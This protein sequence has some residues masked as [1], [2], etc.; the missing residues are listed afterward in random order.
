MEYSI[1]FII[2]AAALLLILSIVLSKL[3]SSLAVPALLVFLAIGMLAGSEGLGGIYFDN[4]WVAQFTGVLA[5]V[6][7]IFAGGFHT[8]WKNIQPILKKGSILSTIGVFITALLVGVFTHYAF[9]V[10]LLTCLLLGAIVSSTDAAAV[11]SVLRSKNVNLKGDLAPLLEFESASNDPMAV[12]LTVGVIQVTVGADA[13]SF[14]FV[15]FFIKQLAIGAAAGFFMGNIIV[16]IMKK[17]HLEYTGLYPPLAIALVLITYGATALLEG[18]GFL[19]V[20]IVGLI[21][22]RNEFPHKKNLMHFHN[23]LAWLMQIVMFVI[24]GL[25]VFP[26]RLK[27]IIVPGLAISAFLM[28]VARPVSVFL[29]LAFSKIK[30][31]EKVLISWVGLRGSVPIVLATFPLMAGV[32]DADIIFNV[33]FFIVLT[34]V[35]IQGTSIPIV[36]KLLKLDAP[37]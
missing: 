7:I 10:P 8:E 35:L 12:L 27:G 33:V 31:R 28:L 2:S 24:L 9:D 25:L 26:S 20:Y 14:S 16:I 19:A 11:F 22:A 6:L 3:V 5:L 21:M 17:L 4:A 30:V 1:E 18:S 36:A 34:S 37:K 23:G 32:P 29:P 15:L 13:A